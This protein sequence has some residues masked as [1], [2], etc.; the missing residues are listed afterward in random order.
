MNKGIRL[1]P[2]SKGERFEILDILRGFALYGVLMSNLVWFFSGYGS[3]DPEIAASFSTFKID[4]IV[5]E[6]ETFLVVNKFISIFSFL[7]GIG[8]AIQLNRIIQ[9][10]GEF[11]PF[12]IRRMMWLFFIGLISIFLMGLDILHLYAILGI[13]LI[14]SRSLS[15]R[16]LLF[17]GIIYTIVLPILIHYFVWVA[18]FIF[19]EQFNLEQIFSDKWDSVVEFKTAFYGRNYFDVIRANFTDAW[20]WFTT[21]D[22]ITTGA[23]SF[24]LFLLGHYLGRSNILIKLKNGL[25]KTDKDNFYKVLRWSLIVGIVS[26]GILL[27]DIPILKNKDLIWIR[28]FRE[29]FW[30]VGVLALALF[31]TCAL[32]YAHQSNKSLK[33]FHYFSVVG[34]MALTNFVGQSV[35]C[36]FIFY[37]LGIYGKVGPTISVVLTTIIYLFQVLFSHW[38]LKRFRYGPLEWLWRSLTY[39]KLEAIRHP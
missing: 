21:D 17:W 2:V 13:C 32:T 34:R 24:G 35:I 8:F 4:S 9:K 19:G 36:F 1:K 22:F 10:G 33:I 38:W 27:L 20:A 12:Y 30:R 31:Y 3:L 11:T 15:N 14:F 23:S 37:V 39:G 16:Q 5:L 18:P 26:Q 6:V 29:L 28:V 25:S 7:F